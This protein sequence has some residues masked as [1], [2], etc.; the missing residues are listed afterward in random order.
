ME[1]LSRKKR[2]DNGEM[3]YCLVNEYGVIKW[4]GKD[5]PPYDKPKISIA[6]NIRRKQRG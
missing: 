6:E 2:P 5:R 3:E 4:L 1:R